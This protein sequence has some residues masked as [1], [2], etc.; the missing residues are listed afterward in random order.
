M[1]FRWWQCETV[2][3]PAPPPPLPPAPMPPSPW[4]LQREGALAQFPDPTTQPLKGG[5]V[6]LVPQYSPVP[7][8]DALPFL[9]DSRAPPL[10]PGVH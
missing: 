1:G 7:A 6:H 2:K 4:P 3:T 10:R 8:S 9:V 5:H